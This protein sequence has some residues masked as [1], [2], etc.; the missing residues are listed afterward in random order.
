MI[1]PAQ[2]DLFAVIGDPVAHSLSPAMMNALFKGLKLA[3]TYVALQVDVLAESLEILAQVGFRGL[4]VTL[5]HKEAA[6]RLAKE[7]DE[8]AESI[9][10]VNTLRLHEG[11]YVGLNTDWLGANR[12]LQRLI[13]LAAKRV[14]VIGAGGVARAVVYGL[15]R[16]RAE[17]TIFNR[18]IERGE[19]VAKLFDCAFHPLRDLSVPGIGHD[20]DVVV[21]CTSVGLSGEETLSLVPETFFEREMV[22]MDT[23]YRPVKT[24]FLKAAE[25]AG[26]HTISGLEMLAY[27]GAAQVEWWFDLSLPDE[28]LKTMKIALIR[29]LSDD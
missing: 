28:A 7:V 1:R 24:P 20:F 14:A 4:S 10:A 29:A 16:E 26:C 8:T 13:S 2:T 11:R 9:G 3:A 12:A 27:Q 23:V 6:Y 18:N 5:P 25:N 15:K 17:V 19:T 22:V 21:Q